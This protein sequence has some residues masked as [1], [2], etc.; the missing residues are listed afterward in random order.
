VAD[1]LGIDRVPVPCRFGCREP[2]VAIVHRPGGRV[3]FDD[4]LQALCA[5]H[6]AKGLRN[7]EG[8]VI[9]WLHPFPPA[10]GARSTRGS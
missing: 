7:D 3:C 2:A 10:G 5:R 9:A 4:P 8:R 1:D 6:L